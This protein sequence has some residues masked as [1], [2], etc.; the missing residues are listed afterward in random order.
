MFECYKEDKYENDM[1][2]INILAKVDYY[3]KLITQTRLEAD[4]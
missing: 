1:N 4:I 3:S 2:V